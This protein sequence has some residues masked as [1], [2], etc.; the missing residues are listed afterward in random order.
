MS[1]WN[2]T[3]PAFASGS[4][5]APRSLRIRTAGAYVARRRR[6]RTAPARSE[7]ER[8]I[9]DVRPVFVSTSA[10]F[11]CGKTPIEKSR[12][13]SR[14]KRLEP[15]HRQARRDVL[16]EASVQPRAPGHAVCGST[17]SGRRRRGRG[18]GPARRSP[19][20]SVAAGVR[21]RRSDPGRGRSRPPSRPDRRRRRG[22]GSRGSR[23]AASGMIQPAWLWP[24]RPTRA[25]SI[26][27]CAAR[28]R[29][30]AAASRASTSIASAV[31]DSPGYD[32]ARLTDPALVVGEDGD[33]VPDEERLQIG[34]VR[35]RRRPGAVHERDRGVATRARRQRSAFPRGRRRRSGSAPRAAARRLAPASTP[36]TAAPLASN[37]AVPAHRRRAS[38]TRF[39][40]ANAPS[41]RVERVHARRSRD[42]RVG[43][44]PYGSSTTPRMRSPT[45]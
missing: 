26:S 30:A 27:G 29:T 11:A 20:R 44:G 28:K 38:R 17:G 39:R 43:P 31:G 7:S 9:S 40:C 41:G 3:A 19:R 1:P 2:R 10:W 33:A 34:E 5:R 21:P 4:Q 37:L 25:G 24:A 22:S 45:E 14:G 18:P 13:G 15:P 6:P 23:V 8:S 32:A 16:V 42:R 35:A 36:E 12:P